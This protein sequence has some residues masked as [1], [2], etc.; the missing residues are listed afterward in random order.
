MLRCRACGRGY[1]GFKVMCDCGGILDCVSRPSGSFD[2]LLD[3]RF[4]DIRRYLRFLPLKERFLPTL[5]LPITPVV[6]RDIDG[7][8]VFFKLEYLMPS[9]SF[10]DRGTYVTVSLF[11]E[12]EI[13]E[14]TLDSSGNAAISL[15][16]FS[17][18]EGFKAHIFIPAHTSEGKKRLLRDLGAEV[19][20]VEGSRMEVHERAK[21]F[22]GG[23]YVSHWYN[24]YFLEGT[25]VVALEAYE[26][27]GSLDYVLSPVGSGSLFIGLYRGFREL[28]GFGKTSVPRMVAVQAKGYESLCER[29]SEK[30][31]L[32]E[33][34]AIPDPPRRGEMMEILLKTNG[35]C[36]SVGDG[37]IREAME[38]LL[39]FGFLVE[40]T[41][42]STYAGFKLLLRDGYFREGSKILIPLTGSGLKGIGGERK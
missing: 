26:Q 34:I 7:L 13:E 36:V 10:K 41:S 3:E 21:S 4:L 20:E 17:K 14:V 5:N 9:G 30:S 15:A 37:E 23:L 28:E 24:P 12:L 22:R 19:H 6:Q 39:R 16:L 42:A 8:D 27:I 38:E 33:G 32:A 2:E 40:P 31:S 11:K 18:S 1:E 25:K 35:A 29:S